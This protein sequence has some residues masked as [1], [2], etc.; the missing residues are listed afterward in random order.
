MECPMAIR[1]QKNRIK[2]KKKK[3]KIVGVVLWIECV[4]LQEHC[5]WS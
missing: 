5:I 3:I 2:I 4:E 1:Y